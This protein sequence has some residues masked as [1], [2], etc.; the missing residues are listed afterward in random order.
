MFN[1]LTQ[2]ESEQT[3]LTK[4]A[5]PSEASEN[6]GWSYWLWVY[7]HLRIHMP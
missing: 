4:S 1:G 2:E 6:D 7:V 5:E 3:D